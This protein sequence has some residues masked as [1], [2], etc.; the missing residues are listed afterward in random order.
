MLASDWTEAHTYY[1]G[2]PSAH[3]LVATSFPEVNW[4]RLELVSWLCARRS[5]EIEAIFEEGDSGPTFP[6]IVL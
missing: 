5:G 2:S 4:Q 1:P 3:S 6:A